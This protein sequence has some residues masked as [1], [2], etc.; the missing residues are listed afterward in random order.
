[1][2]ERSWGPFSGRHLTVIIVAALA[3]VG[4]PGTVWAV[5]TFTNVAVE[6]PAT[7]VK[8]S[9]DATHHLRVG[10]GTGPLSIDGTVVARQAPA[11]NDTRF[12]GQ[13]VGPCVQ[14][15]TIP[16]GRSLVLTALS[17]SIQKDTTVDRAVGTLF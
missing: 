7:G 13:S 6:D 11:S 15:T 9:V 4:I 2:S 17:T 14:V 12:L 10:D 5:D 16:A 1:M 3:V 8:A